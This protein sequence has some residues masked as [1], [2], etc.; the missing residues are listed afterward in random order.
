MKDGEYGGFYG[1]L[2]F[3]LRLNKKALKGG[4]LNSRILWFFSN[5]YDV[6]SD[7]ECLSYAEHA[8]RFLRDSLLDREY[9]GVYWSVDY[10]GKPLDDIK[11]TYNQAFAIYALASYYGVSKNKEAL[12]IAYDIVE[13][14]EAKCKDDIGYLE[15]FDRCF[16]PIS[17]DKLSE[18]GVMATRTMNTLLH[19]FE[20][21]TELYRVDHSKMIADRMKWILDLF[22]TKVYNP[23]LRRLEVFFDYD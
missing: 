17:N 11:H 8:Y 9:G 3:D 14:V 16:R 19:I 10:D 13:L 20:A 23:K 18:N 4:I 15:A 21:Y 6:T 7:E 22:E 5:A 2:S 12:G 1:K